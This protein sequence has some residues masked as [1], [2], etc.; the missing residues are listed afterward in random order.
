MT[1]ARNSP[2]VIGLEEHFVTDAVLKA[3]QE[4]DPQWQDLSLAPS[5]HGE[6]GRRLAE[7]DGDR[8]AAMDEAGV[9]VQVLSLST[10]GV[11]TLGAGDA[12]ALATQTND[13]VRGHRLPD[14]PEERRHRVLRPVRTTD[15]D[16]A[17]SLSQCGRTGDSADLTPGWYTN[18]ALIRH[19]RTVA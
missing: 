17:G 9:D 13:L 7:L 12:V 8:V 15:D 1:T 19:V 6:S 18:V 14:V 5:A 2:K 4:L 11:Q 16:T 3:W 10:P